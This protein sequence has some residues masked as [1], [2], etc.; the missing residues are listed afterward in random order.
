M[1]GPSHGSNDGLGE[2][3]HEGQRYE[4]VFKEAAAKLG[5][6]LRRGKQ[7]IEEAGRS[8][9][10]DSGPR[11]PTMRNRVSGPGELGGNP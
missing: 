9:M 1:L 6:S 11:A 10:D 4:R 7:R 5:K 3:G 2:H 8:V